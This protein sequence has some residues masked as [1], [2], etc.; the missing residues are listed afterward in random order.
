M[1]TTRSARTIVS[2]GIVIKHGILNEYTAA[3]ALGVVI[4][5]H[6][7]IAGAQNHVHAAAIAFVRV[8][9]VVQDKAI[10]DLAIVTIAIDAGS[11]SGI[12]VGIDVIVRH[13]AV[14]QGHAT[15]H[16]YART[17]V[18]VGLIVGIE[19]MANGETVPC[20]TFIFHIS[21]L[22]IFPTVGIG[23]AFI[24]SGHGVA[25][26]LIYPFIIPPWKMIN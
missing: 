6:S 2:H 10:D 3:L 25:I 17:A 5:H 21:T 9:D 8:V 22:L 26:T 16:A 1:Q 4:G 7:V 12:I 11:T 24:Y 14:L 20:G 15:E 19:A 23:S 18:T 13:H